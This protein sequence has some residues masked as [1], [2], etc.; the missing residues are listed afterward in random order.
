MSSYDISLNHA[1]Y[2]AALSSLKTGTENLTPP[3][4]DVA[5]IVCQ[6]DTMIKY[7]EK[8]SEIEAVLEQYKALLQRDQTALVSVQSNFVKMDGVLAGGLSALTA[9]E[10]GK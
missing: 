7:R 1:I 4:T 5:A 9:G 3:T 10:E 6:A 2:E 8:L